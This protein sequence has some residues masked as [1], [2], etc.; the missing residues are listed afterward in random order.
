METIEQT[1][2]PY[3]QETGSE[4]GWIDMFPDMCPECGAKEGEYHRDG[5]D[6]EECLKCHQ[7]L[8]S[9]SCGRETII[10]FNNVNL[11]S[12]KWRVGCCRYDEKFNEIVIEKPNGA[13]YEVTLDRGKTAAGCLDWIHQV[14][15][16]T[17]GREVIGDFLELFFNRIPSELWSGQA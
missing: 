9:C 13:V 12:R 3:G 14:S 4:V 6:I 16:K 11:E 17:W 10:D 15:A 8:I 5:C 1:W 2:V 7:Q